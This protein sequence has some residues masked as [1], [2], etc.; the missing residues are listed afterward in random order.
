MRLWRRAED[1]SRKRATAP[2]G[3][4]LASLAPACAQCIAV[5]L[6]ARFEQ[7]SRSTDTGMHSGPL[8]GSRAPR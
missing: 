6:A 3:Y 1:A 5:T 8:P 4:C 7:R 2:A